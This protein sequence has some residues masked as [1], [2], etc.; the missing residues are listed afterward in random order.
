LNYVLIIHYRDR[1]F[2]ENIK[3]EDMKKIIALMAS[4]YLTTH[5]IACTSS[6]SKEGG[7]DAAAAEAAPDAGFDN[8]GL[9][10]SSTPP[11]AENA[12]VEKVDGLEG[13]LNAA[14]GS[15]LKGRL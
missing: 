15:F 13:D 5:L 14:S 1:T 12:G 9:D 7:T 4:I 8:G 10:G 11:A 3:E 2:Q 6:D